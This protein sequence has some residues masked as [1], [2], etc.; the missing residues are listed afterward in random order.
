MSPATKEE[1]QAVVEETRRIASQPPHPASGEHP[2]PTMIEATS[3]GTKIA[4]G[5]AIALA[6]AALTGGVVWGQSSAK[7]ADTQATA[8]KALQKASAHDIDIALNAEQH[9]Q[10]LE[11]LKEI[12][13]DVKEVK[14]SLKP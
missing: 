10:I 12:K 9:K 2:V 4:V 13:Q 7:L 14:H 1:I 3:I 8:D 5:V 11:A 6:S